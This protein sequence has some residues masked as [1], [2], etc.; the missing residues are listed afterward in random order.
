MLQYRDYVNRDWVNRD[1]LEG[2]GPERRGGMRHAGDT[3][4]AGVAELADALDLGSSDE[5]R[6]GSNP[7][8]RT[9]GRYPVP[10]AGGRE[11]RTERRSCRGKARLVQFQLAQSKSAQAQTDARNV[12][13]LP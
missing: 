7:P 4:G 6:G 1:W 11:G 2:A 10:R 12:S 3:A 5:N 13:T 8:A 9:N